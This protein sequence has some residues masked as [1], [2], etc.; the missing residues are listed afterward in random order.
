MDCL[1]LLLLK[2]SMCKTT[3]IIINTIINSNI[4]ISDEINLCTRKT[5]GTI[6][7]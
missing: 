4:I 2:F 6:K 5:N 3:L 1:K 7:T